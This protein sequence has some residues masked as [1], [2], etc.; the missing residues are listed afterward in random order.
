MMSLDKF[1]HKISQDEDTDEVRKFF[2]G[3]GLYWRVVEY[4]C[5]GHKEIYGRLNSFLKYPEKDGPRK[6]FFHG[7]VFLPGRT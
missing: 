6:W 3:W 2:D 1:K 4:D 7:L 5:A